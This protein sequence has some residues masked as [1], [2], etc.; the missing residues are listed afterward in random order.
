MVSLYEQ[1]ERVESMQDLV[2]VLRLLL[3]DLEKNPS[4]WENMTLSTYLE[5]LSAWINDSAGFFENRGE[6][7]PNVPNWRL[8]ATALVAAA[9]YE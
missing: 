9:R 3:A 4:S 6:E 5:A 8:L 1:A 2:L 7:V